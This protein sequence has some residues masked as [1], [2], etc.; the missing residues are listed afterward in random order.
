M[1]KLTRITAVALSAALLLAPLAAQAQQPPAAPAPASTATQTSGA[2]EARPPK[3]NFTTH[4]LA[5][6]LE[7]IF[8]EDHSDPIISLQLW[9][10]VG[11]KDELPGHSGF[12]HLF[13]H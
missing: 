4:K 13:E 10:H 11:A 1:N 8:L 2:I 5:N 9:Y 12:A 6:G 7:L 3:L